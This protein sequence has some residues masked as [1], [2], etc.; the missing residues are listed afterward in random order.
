MSHWTEGIPNDLPTIQEEE[1]EKELPPKNGIPTKH[2][3]SDDD[4]QKDYGKATLELSNESA[5]VKPQQG[6]PEKE[7]LVNDFV[8]ILDEITSSKAA[9]K[10]VELVKANMMKQV[11]DAQKSTQEQAYW[12]NF[13]KHKEPK[14]SQRI[15]NSDPCTCG[16]GAKYKRCCK[17]SPEE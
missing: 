8:K 15:K 6:T 16:S 11:E 13:L 4:D 2:D 10:M 5:S 1:N 17:P 9:E 14:K 7:K 3:L 12:D